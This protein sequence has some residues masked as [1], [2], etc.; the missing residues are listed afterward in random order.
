MSVSDNERKRRFYMFAALAAAL[1]AVILIVSFALLGPARQDTPSS[2]RA[3]ATERVKG[4]AGG[5]G[6]DEYNRKLEK[7]DEIQASEALQAGDSY[8]ATPV[9]RK[10]P[11]VTK[12][13]EKAPPPPAPAPAPRPVQPPRRQQADNAFLKRLLEDLNT[14]DARLSA[15][16]AAQGSIV[17]QHD[18]SK[19]A[20]ADGPAP[21]A[22]PAAG[23]DTGSPADV[24]PGDL[25]YAVVDTG[26]NSDVPSAVMATVTA[27]KHRGM[28][29][30]GRFQRHDERLLL[31][32]SR[33]VL[34]DG[35]SVQL[36]AYAVDP[37]TS[38]ASVAS[39]VD[40]H[41]LSRWGGLVASAFLEGLGTAKRFSGAQSTIYDG[42]STDQL[43]W[44]DYSVQDQAWI[45]AGKVGE[46]AGKIIERHF[47]R[48]PTVRLEAGTPIGVLILDLKEGGRGGQGGR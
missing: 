36:D 37:D 25:L 26:V 16:S 33:A 41:F 27:G 23:A 4:G 40:T 5:T 13:E 24:R 30:I 45:A 34:A 18:F 29:L 8:I 11:L 15:T 17:Y 31:A 19:D 22:K 21:T 12:K 10:T 14:L 35:R 20:R 6:S 9:G 7:H 38:E 48:P 44:G 1:V 32:F 39:S 46:K 2:L 42:G 28:K 47:D 43:A 3:S